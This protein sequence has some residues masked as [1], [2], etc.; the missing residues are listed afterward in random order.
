MVLKLTCLIGL[1]IAPLLAEPM[2]SE[3]KEIAIVEEKI[4]ASALEKK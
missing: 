1:V 3:S 4:E 2:D